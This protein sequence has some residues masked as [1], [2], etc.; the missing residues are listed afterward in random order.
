MNRFP[1]LS[2]AVPPREFGSPPPSDS[3]AFV[4]GPPSPELPPAKQPQPATV[5]IIPPG[6]TLRMRLPP[7]EMYRLPSATNRLPA[8]STATLSGYSCA[9]VAGPPS[10]E[11]PSVPLPAT[12]VMVPLAETRRIRRLPRSA[13]N[14][15]PEP[16][17]ARPVDSVSI[18]CAFVAGP[19]SP[20]KPAVPVPA[21]VVMIPLG[22]TF[23]M[24]ALPS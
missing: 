10:P 7:P 9:L 24:R 8:P 4:A 21:T 5:V 12:V 3:R 11:R 23:R 15:L 6:E 18:S 1:A 13:R 17:T 19:S 2:T 20:E 22:E 16:S 14:R